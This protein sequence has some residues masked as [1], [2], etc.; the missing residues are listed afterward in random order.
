MT[1]ASMR[2]RSLLFV[3]GDSE[4]KFARACVSGADVLFLDLEDA[5]APSMKAAARAMVAGW[6]D[7]AAD[8]VPRLFVRIN[9]LDTGM[10]GDDLAAVV[11]PGLA[12]ILV[13]KADGA[14]DVARVAALLDTLEADAGMAP[15]TVKIMV[16]A[17][18]TPAA[19]FA[20][21]SY[22]PSHPR[23]AALTWGA[24]DLAAAIGA[25]A[26]KE[27]DGQWTEPYR[28]ARSLCLFAAASAGVVPIDTI[29]A[30][31]R[32]TAGLEADC[33]RARRDGFLGRLAIHP[34]Q[35]EVINRCFSP[36]DADIAEARKIVAAFAAQP[37]TGTI[38]ID[39]KMY[40]IPHL[41]A[42]RKTL[43]AAGE[44]L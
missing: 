1:L 41:K 4:K 40:D 11:R 18:E 12:G 17:T 21:G 33:R 9:P 44:T 38:G 13:P 23:L 32:D 26:N 16:V 19:M 30:D 27:A 14:G 10:A 2:T 37:D 29:Y 7:R 35:V 3:P 34:D 28:L 5:V 31:F 42:A 8:V 24:E 22:T 20:L 25:T 39:G 15:G 6:V 36:S 43:A